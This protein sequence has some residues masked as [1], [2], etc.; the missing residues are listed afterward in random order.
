MA[1]N[2]RTKK[3]RTTS[4][5]SPQPESKTASS[6][7]ERREKARALSRT[8]RQERLLLLGVLGI[9]IMAFVNSLDGQFV[10]DD[11]YQILKNPTLSSPGN[12]PRM[13]TQGV[14]QFLN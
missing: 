7:H 2:R 12:I 5:V 4:T 14:W 6:R 1:R 11:R 9:T 8:K 13:F 10:Y 3:P